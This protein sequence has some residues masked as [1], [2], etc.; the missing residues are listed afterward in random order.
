VEAERSYRAA[1]PHLEKAQLLDQ[2]EL[3]NPLLLAMCRYNLAR[4]LAD[5][6]QPQEAEAFWTSALGVWKGLTLMRPQSSE[7]HSRTGATLGNLAA[8]AR[9]R[10][11]FQECCDLATQ[12]LQYQRRAL[13][14]EPV[15]EEA[16]GFLRQ[17]YKQFSMALE[18]LGDREALTRCAEE[19]LLDLADVPYEVCAAAVSFASCAEQAHN[20]AD[21]SA[22]DRERLI[23]DCALRARAILDEAKE[24]FDD[25]GAR[26]TVAQAYVAI[27]DRF[28]QMDRQ[29][30]SRRAWQAA[31]AIFEQLRARVAPKDQHEF[32]PFIKST[33]ERLGWPTADSDGGQR[34]DNETATE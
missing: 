23:Y 13:K 3:R 5:N 25:D 2:N 31:K 6:G 16:K 30:D 9:L 34:L 12:A 19:R 21:L 29:D 28:A 8:L 17:H 22:A 20:A 32:D 14:L 7:F 4:V 15:Y 33:E 24:R 10:G 18:S 27:G 26:F 1:L 11:D